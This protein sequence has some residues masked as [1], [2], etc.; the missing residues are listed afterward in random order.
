MPQHAKNEDKRKKNR[1]QSSDLRREFI[2]PQHAKNENNKEK[3]GAQRRFRARILQCPS[4]PTPTTLVSTKTNNN[5]HST[6]HAEK[7]HRKQTNQFFKP[8]TTPKTITKQNKKT[9]TLSCLV[10]VLDQSPQA[11][12][13]RPQTPALGKERGQR[14]GGG[15]R[16]RHVG[17]G[18]DR[19]QIQTFAQ[20]LS[21]S[22]HFI[23]T[24]KTQHQTK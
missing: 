3:Q 24:T 14:A 19:Y 11:T 21:H 17:V 2:M 1:E 23:H 8:T 7:Q 10:T 18:G 4:T 5:T 12:D 16:P 22:T 15:G 6:E 20:E 9:K 13:H